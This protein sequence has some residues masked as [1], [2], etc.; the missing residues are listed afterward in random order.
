MMFFGMHKT[1]DAN[2]LLRKN[3]TSTVV[4]KNVEQKK[5]EKPSLFSKAWFKIMYYQKVINA[6]IT[7]QMRL[8]KDGDN[9]A[10]F[11]ALGLAFVYGVI[12]AVGPGHG[13][14]IISSYYMGN[15][16]KK[17]QAPIMALSFAVTHSI[18]AIIVVWSV[19]KI[20]G[21]MLGKPAAEVTTVK[22]ISY[23][24]IFAIGLYMLYSAI[25]NKSHNHSHYSHGHETE[26][27]KLEDD[28]EGVCRSMGACCSH[29]VNLKHITER[30]NFLAF[31]TGLAPCAG[32]L[33]VMVYAMANGIVM[34]G[35]MVVAA[36][37]LGMATTLTMVGIVVIASRQKVIKM[38][39]GNSK[40]YQNAGRIAK[41]L[42]ALFIML[43][44]VVMFWGALS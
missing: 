21:Y 23:A 27:G 40:L 31:V 44:G 2:P 15:D 26:A 22:L 42:S 35:V 20:S 19:D 14:I 29:Y 43:I 18:S 33:L 7:K 10:L 9:I 39:D 30:P 36:I 6:K 13:K 4:E 16:A 1:A 32:S 17:M 11:W 8:I 5:E 3:E 12:H 25:R 41:A 34:T 38:F 37:T 24:M 28:V